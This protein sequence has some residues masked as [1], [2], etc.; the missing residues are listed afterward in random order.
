MALLISLCSLGCGRGAATGVGAPTPDP[1]RLATETQAARATGLHLWRHR[2]SAGRGAVIRDTIAVHVCTYLTGQE[3]FLGIAESEKL[4]RPEEFSAMVAK[5]EHDSGPGFTLVP[6]IGEGG[7]YY[8]HTS[9]AITIS[10]MGFLVGGRAIEIRLAGTR[11]PYRAAHALATVVARN[12]A[13]P[14]DS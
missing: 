12:L 5:A 7:Y 2:R 14:S 8:A 6:A 11:M 3:R 10:T 4:L 9:H 1:C 13:R